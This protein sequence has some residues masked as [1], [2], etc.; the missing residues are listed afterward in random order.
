MVR[1]FPAPDGKLFG[2]AYGSDR[3]WALDQESKEAIALSPE[4][5]RVMKRLPIPL[6]HPLALG[7]WD[8]GLAVTQQEDPKRLVKLDLETGRIVREI[9][10]AKVTWPWG[11]AEVD[12]ELWFHEAW[13]GMDIRLDPDR[14]EEPKYQPVAGPGLHLAATPDG[15][16]QA[17]D[18]GPVMVKNSTE[19]KLLDWAEQPFD[20]RCDGIAFDGE[21]LWAL[22]AVNHRVRAI[23]KPAAKEHHVSM[24]SSTHE[25]GS[26]QSRV[27]LD[28]VVADF[29]HIT[30]DLE[31]HQVVVGDITYPQPPGLPDHPSRGDVGG[32]LEGR[33]LR[34]A[35]GR[36]RRL[37]PLR[38]PAQ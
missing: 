28:G 18:F 30:N 27:L 13:E 22:D 1:A 37:R 35:R 2:L 23:E 4:D 34:H 36:V 20:G 10:L 32:R 16:W 11:F 6:D 38:L 12:G 3:L 7:W 19:G 14:P 8:G 21:R 31:C 15:I 17:H 33:R 29:K 26:T 5:G 25:G 24:G 9:S